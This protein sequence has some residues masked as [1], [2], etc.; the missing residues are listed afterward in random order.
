[1]IDVSNYFNVYE[2]KLQIPRI[3]VLF[4]H[5]IQRVEYSVLDIFFWLIYNTVPK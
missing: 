3:C 2:Q 1:M 4:V 5:F